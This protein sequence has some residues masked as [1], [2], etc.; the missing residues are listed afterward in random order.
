MLTLLGNF[1]IPLNF[2]LDTKASNRA[3]IQAKDLALIQCRIVNKWFMVL[4]E[5]NGIYDTKPV[6]LIVG[7]SNEERDR[8]VEGFMERVEC[9]VWRSIG[10]AA[11][12]G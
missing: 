10:T 4:V 12:I 3:R 2:W 6:T 8:A 9:L 5:C 1:S 11:A 7:E